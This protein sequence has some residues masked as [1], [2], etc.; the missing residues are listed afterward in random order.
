LLMES[1]GYRGPFERFFARLSLIGTPLA[2]L[3]SAFVV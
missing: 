2:I 1:V 3:V